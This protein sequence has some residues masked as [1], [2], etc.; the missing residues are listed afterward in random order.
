MYSDGS[1]AGNGY[2]FGDVSGHDRFS[3]D[4]DVNPLKL[5]M[6]R[7]VMMVVVVLIMMLMEMMLAIVMVMVMAQT[8]NENVNKQTLNIFVY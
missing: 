3:V 2:G 8:W 4:G 6:V 7:V 5:M 1:S